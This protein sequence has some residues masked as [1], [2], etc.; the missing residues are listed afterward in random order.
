MTDLVRLGNAAFRKSDS[1]TYL[2]NYD[3]AEPDE[4]TVRSM[5]Y[6]FGHG[7]LRTSDFAIELKW[8]D[9]Q[10]LMASFVEMNHPEALRIQVALR[11]A[12][13][14]EQAGW[15]PSDLPKIN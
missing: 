4:K 6:S 12:E 1:R 3:S 7:S 2:V 10:T 8:E 11:L 9:M 15:S 5:F 13:A 14:A